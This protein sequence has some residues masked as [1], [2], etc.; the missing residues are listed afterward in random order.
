MQEGGGGER[1]GRGGKRGGGEGRPGD[2]V[3]A[4]SESHKSTQ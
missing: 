3:C 1:G 4:T 2:G